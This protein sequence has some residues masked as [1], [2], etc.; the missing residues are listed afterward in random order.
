MDWFAVGSVG[1]YPTPGVTTTQRAI[2]AAS[3]GLLA[4]AP[5][6]SAVMAMYQ[7]GLH[8]VGLGMVMR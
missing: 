1:P 3:Y 6:F 2:Y 7:R 4:L 5:D 8:G